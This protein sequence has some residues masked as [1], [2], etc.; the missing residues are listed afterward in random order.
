MPSQHGLSEEAVTD[1]WDK[2]GQSGVRSQQH[3]NNSLAR[4]DD[5]TWLESH[6]SDLGFSWRLT[7]ETS[8]WLAHTPVTPAAAASLPL[9][10]WFPQHNKE[11]PRFSSSL[12]QSHLFTVCSDLVFVFSFYVCP[13]SSPPSPCCSLS[14]LSLS[15]S[16]PFTLIP[17]SH[18]S[19]DWQCYKLIFSPVCS[20]CVSLA[21]SLI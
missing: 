10:I 13:L 4:S 8:S 20:L 21:I 6:H 17:S 12:N 15:L 1:C 19:T 11:S 2:V 16:P 18:P 3:V 14:P 5:S 9:S 7:R